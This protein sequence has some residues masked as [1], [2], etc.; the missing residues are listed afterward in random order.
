MNQIEALHQAIDQVE[1][2]TNVKEWF[3]NLEAR[4]K[5]EAEFHDYSHD[6]TTEL[7]NLKFYT[8]TG[9]SNKYV[10]NWIRQNSKG[11]I[12]LDYAC[13]NGVHSVRAAEYGANFVIG[14]DISPG[15]IANAKKMAISRNLS[16]STRFFVGDCEQT[17]LPDNSVDTII[18][19]GMLHHLDL[20]YAFPEMKR[21]LKP[22]GK[23]LAVEALNYNP[24]I[25]AYRF[26][27]P[28]MRTEW[29]KHHI[30]SLKEVG[31]AKKYFKLN[32]V[33]FWHITSFG[34][35]F[36]GS[37]KWLLNLLN[38]LDSILTKMPIIKLLSWQ[39][40]FELEKD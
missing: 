4:K 33:K 13:G 37:P 14:I 21:I 6:E 35:A 30:L 24:F 15:S 27:T 8:T 2:K 11:K 25:K 32:N 34:A 22:G 31:L 10:D 7:E 36:L 28:A 23:I 1:Q 39:F 29:E 38:G 18:C 3:D 16:N 26:L 9:L 5:A 20:N 40:T 17:G 12:F 19:L